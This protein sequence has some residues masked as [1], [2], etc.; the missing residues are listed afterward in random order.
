[1]ATHQI[2]RTSCSWYHCQ[3]G[4]QSE[5]CSDDMIHPLLTKNPGKIQLGAH[6]EFAANRSDQVICR[7]KKILYQVLSTACQGYC[8][9]HLAQQPVCMFMVA[10]SHRSLHINKWADSMDQL[11]T[12]H[13]YATVSFK[14]TWS[15]ADLPLPFL[16][17]IMMTSNRLSTRQINRERRPLF[18]LNEH[19]ASDRL[20]HLWPL[21]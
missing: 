14:F 17:S 20:T 4:I 11:G 1:M 7:I 15:I 21:C 3:F 19:D 2:E 5:Q 10:S 16:R 12:F 18:R 9:P 13:I 6:E 8:N